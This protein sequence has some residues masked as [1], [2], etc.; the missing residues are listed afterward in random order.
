MGRGGSGLEGE[1]T[2]G[3]CWRDSCQF[4]M[5]AASWKKGPDCWRSSVNAFFPIWTEESHCSSRAM[6]YPVRVIKGT[7]RKWQVWGI[8]PVCP[9]A[10]DAVTLASSSALPELGCK[11]CHGVVHCDNSTYPSWR[12]RIGELLWQSI[13]WEISCCSWKGDDWI[14]LAATWETTFPTSSYPSQFSVAPE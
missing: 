5:K 7:Y 2:D 6:E 12:E 14:A 1:N 10:S 9:N 8:I 3:F 4:L 13:F 11:H